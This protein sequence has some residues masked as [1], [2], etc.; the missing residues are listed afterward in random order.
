MALRCVVVGPRSTALPNEQMAWKGFGSP[1]PLLCPDDNC[2]GT[3]LLLGW[4]EEQCLYFAPKEMEV[5][6]GCRGGGRRSGTLVEIAPNRL[7]GEVSCWRNF[8][9]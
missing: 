1:T 6:C 2:R 9:A 8:C 7:W 4:T 3:R 5:R